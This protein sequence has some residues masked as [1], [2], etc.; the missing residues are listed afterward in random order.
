MEGNASKLEGIESEGVRDSV[1]GS[2]KRVGKTYELKILTS[3]IS[4]RTT[5]TVS[6]ARR[7]LRFKAMAAGLCA[8]YLSF[9]RKPELL[10]R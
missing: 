7:I 10:F 3:P 2:P 4:E 5:D 8:Q 1:I 6:R 9:Y